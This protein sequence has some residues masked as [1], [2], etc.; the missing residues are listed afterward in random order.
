MV[1]VSSAMATRHYRRLV[2]P[3][4]GAGDRLI[5]FANG[6]LSVVRKPGS[7]PRGRAPSLPARARECPCFVMVSKGTCLHAGSIATQKE[8]NEMNPIRRILVGVAVAGSLL[9]GGVIGAA[10]AGPLAASA[11]TTTNVAATAATPSAGSGTFV[12]NENATHEAGESAARE[13]QENAG[14]VPTVP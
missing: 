13:A 7:A 1:S 2:V 4:L 10:I 12:P 14:Q 3:R 11:A 5:P 8:V 6:P 9:T